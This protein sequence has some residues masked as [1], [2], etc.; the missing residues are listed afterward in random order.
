[1]KIRKVW[2]C[3]YNGD[4][5]KCELLLLKE[6]TSKETKYNYSKLHF[7]TTSRLQAL[8]FIFKNKPWDLK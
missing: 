1:M 7:Y 4:K 6:D 8:M 3:G 5:P 2:I